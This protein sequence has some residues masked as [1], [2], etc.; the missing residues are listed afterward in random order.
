MGWTSR[1]TGLPTASVW[2]APS[3]TL[4]IFM[5]GSYWA[6][7][8]NRGIGGWGIVR[9]KE[10]PGRRPA[11]AVLG[12]TGEQQIAA[13]RELLS[14][15][16]SDEDVRDVLK[17]LPLVERPGSR[18]VRMACH[19]RPGAEAFP[20]ESRDRALLAEFAPEVL[21]SLA[22]LD[23]RTRNRRIRGK[24]RGITSRREAAK[25]FFLLMDLDTADAAEMEALLGQ[26]EAPPNAAGPESSRRSKPRWRSRCE[27]PWSRCWPKS[28]RAR[29]RTCRRRRMPFPS[30]RASSVRKQRPRSYDRSMSV[31]AHESSR[32]AAAPED[33]KK[34][35]RQR[36]LSTLR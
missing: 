32:S 24:T 8:A 18:D 23:D 26:R 5:P 35:S 2:K 28:G 1:S 30:C 34:Q 25:A 12:E 13:V 15:T 36:S 16:V 11:S 29:N 20:Q 21:A 17:D 4:Q 7:V 33:R 9:G 10:G 6:T 31:S 14:S 19:W 22:A 27:W 3:T